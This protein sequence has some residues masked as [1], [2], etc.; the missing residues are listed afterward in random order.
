MPVQTGS[1]IGPYEI[2]GAL[3]AGGMGEVYRARDTR[4]N[5]HVAI[6]SLPTAFAHDPERVARF[7]REAQ[8]LAALNHPHIAGIHGLEESNGSQFL[9]LELVDGETLADRL[10]K[11]PIPLA[12]TL[13]ISRE[14][15]DA[16]EAAH[17]KGIIHRDLKPAN[18]ALTAD[19]KVKVLDFGLA[20]YEAGETST[21]DLTAS[22]TLAYAG[23]QAGI[24][25]GTAAYMSPEQAKGK[26]VDKRTDVWAFGCLLF[27]M[28]SGKKAFEGEDVSDTLAAILRGEPEWSAL[29]TDVPPAVRSL[30]K[31][32]LEKDR[33]ARIP[34]FSVVRF[35]MTENNAPVSPSALAS[36]A[37]T[38]PP[39]APRR[40]LF[41]WTVAGLLAAALAAVVMV[42]APWRHTPSQAP[43]R[44]TVDVGADTTILPAFTNIALSPDGTTLAFVG[45]ESTSSTQLFVRRLGQLE[46][47]DDRERR[48]GPDAVFLPRRTVA[49]LFQW[50]KTEKGGRRRWRRRHLV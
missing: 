21:P 22:P 34:D 50:R 30:I 44:L 1:R 31:R 19:G 5:R 43:L 17:E 11:G 2:E 7:K 29:P 3:G 38:Q 28:L 48:R 46:G 35:F 25:L 12:E 4:L 9:V 47:D 14:I 49:R 32:C 27:E 8:L 33:R 24:I 18:V 37:A 23:T 6:K 16:L 45:V 20:R 40:Q 39:V 10:A 41:S 36:P 42:W 26:A 15:V 13:T